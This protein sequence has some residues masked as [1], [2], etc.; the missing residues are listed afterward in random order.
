[1]EHGQ[2]IAI[3]CNGL[4]DYIFHFEALTF[5]FTQLY[6]CVSNRATGLMVEAF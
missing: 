2:A 4:N 5:A 3:F 6:R 1:M